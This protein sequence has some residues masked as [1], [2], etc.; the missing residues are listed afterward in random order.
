[1]KSSIYT[2]CCEI[3]K[4]QQGYKYTT[5]YTDVWKK[6]KDDESKWIPFCYFILNIKRGKITLCWKK[7]WMVKVCILFIFD[8]PIIGKYFIFW[9][10]QY[11]NNKLNI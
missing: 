6:T 5:L 7:I 10:T 4:Q 3:N 1:M 2:L 9:R 8:Q 11:K